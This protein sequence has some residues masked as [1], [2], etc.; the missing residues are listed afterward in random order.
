MVVLEIAPGSMV[1]EIDTGDTLGSRLCGRAYRE[2]PSWMRNDGQTPAGFTTV[3]FS[4][5][6]YMTTFV[7]LLFG[8][9]PQWLLVCSCA[10]I[11]Y[12]MP[13]TG[14]SLN[15]T[16]FGVLCKNFL[17][18]FTRLQVVRASVHRRCIPARYAACRAC[19][20]GGP[21]V[22]GLMVAL[23][24]LV[25]WDPW[26]ATLFLSFVPFEA[27]TASG[28]DAWHPRLKRKYFSGAGFMRVLYTGTWMM[29]VALFIIVLAGLQAGAFSTLVPREVTIF[30]QSWSTFEFASERAATM[31]LLQFSNSVAAILSPHNFVSFRAA[32]CLP[33]ASLSTPGGTSLVM[34]LP[35]RR[36]AAD[37]K[38]PPFVRDV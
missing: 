25:Q 35:Q 33:G 23:S 15:A 16:V 32:V 6:L 4:A 20:C 1:T 10:A 21:Q 24:D 2:A 26:S 30:S 7:L 17:W 38:A 28:M 22:A 19:V 37:V 27:V 31:I 29:A 9:A 8:R 3:I 5:S 12:A 13:M 11:F 34:I 36:G 14:L 18:I